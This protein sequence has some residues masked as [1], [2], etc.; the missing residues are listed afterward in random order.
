MNKVYDLVGCCFG[1][2]VLFQGKDGSVVM[3][4]KQ[5]EMFRVVSRL[6]HLLV[7]VFLLRIDCVVTL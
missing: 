6:G 1:V 3:D 7:R 4:L 2:Q 5:G